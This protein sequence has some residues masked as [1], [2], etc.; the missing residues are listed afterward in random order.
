MVDSACQSPIVRQC[1]LL[2][3]NRSKAYYEPKP[4]V[5]EEDLKL[6]RRIDEMHLQRHLMVV[7]D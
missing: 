1:E 2:S 3:L 5:L 7:E 4:D 6:M